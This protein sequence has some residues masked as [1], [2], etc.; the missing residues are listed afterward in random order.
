MLDISG[1]P[2]YEPV[3]ITG[4]VKGGL[5]I[6]HE[7]WGLTE[8]IKNVADRFAQQGYYVIAPN[9][10]SETDIEKIATTELQHSL[11]D[12]KKRNSI[13]PKLRELMAPLQSPDFA[14]KTNDKLLSVFNYLYQKSE[15]KNK[16][17]VIGFC[18]GGTYSF[19]LATLEPKLIVSIPFY[20]HCN[21][22][23]D[24]LHNIICPILAFYGKN[25]EGLMTGFNELQERMNQAGVK[26]NAQIY[27]DCGHAFFNDSN[28]YAYNKIAADDAWQKTLDFLEEHFVSNL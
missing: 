5:I 4:N 19:N 16:V 8:H 13:Q 27:Q 9:L 7:V 24:Q 25:D 6:I 28:P 18:F 22:S 21:H 2:C 17:G 3:D 26:F 15:L 12:P 20:G 1:V 11:F 10:L 14:V 23:V